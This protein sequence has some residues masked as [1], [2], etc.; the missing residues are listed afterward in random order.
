MLLFQDRWPCSRFAV[1][2]ATR[3]TGTR[4]HGTKCELSCLSEG[5][6]AG[7]FGS[8]RDSLKCIGCVGDFFR[9]GPSAKRKTNG[10]SGAFHWQSHE[11]PAPTGPLRGWFGDGAEPVVT[12]PKRSGGAAPTGSSAVLRGAV[13]RH[14]RGPRPRPAGQGL[15]RERRGAPAGRATA[16][17]RRRRAIRRHRRRPRALPH[18]PAEVKI[19]VLNGSGLVGVAGQAT[20]ILN[21]KGYTTIPPANAPAKVPATV[22]YYT[23]GYQADAEAIAAA[24]GTG[25]IGEF[26]R[27]RPPEPS[28]RCRPTCRGPTSSSCSA[29]T[30]RRARPDPTPASW[31]TLRV[32]RRAGCRRVGGR[33]RR[34]AR[35]A[36]RRASR[37]LR[38]H[39]RPDRAR[40]RRRPAHR[41][42]RG[43]AGGSCP[44]PRGRC[45]ARGRGCAPQ[46][47]VPATVV[48]SGVAK[49]SSAASGGSTP[50][51]GG[52]AARWRRRSP[53]RSPTHRPGP[54][55]RARGFPSRST[56][57]SVPTSREPCVSTRRP[58]RSAAVSWPG[59]RGCRWSCIRRSRPEGSALEE[60]S[61]GL[62]G[63]VRRRRCRRPAGLR[64]ARPVAARPGV[65]TGKVAV[66]SVEASP[67]LLVVRRRGRRPRGSA[68]PSGGA[69]RRGDRATDASATSRPRPVARRTSC[70]VCATSPRSA[71]DLRRVARSPGAQ[72]LGQDVG[73]P[74]TSWLTRSGISQL[75]PGARLG[76]E[77]EHRVARAIMA[78]FATRFMPSR[79]GF[80]EDDVGPLEPGHRA[81]K[82]SDRSSARSASRHRRHRSL[83]RRLSVSTSCR[84]VR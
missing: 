51:P 18:Q 56:T 59:R 74:A 11:G 42:R 2:S 55:S 27:C 35:H 61:A 83:T 9:G 38:R 78:S 3:P 31:W 24:L 46:R 6:F 49:W 45:R 33:R 69:G 14:R 75:V 50:T 62:S 81:G 17:P 12:A 43:G 13:R 48:L 21:G 34:S 28:L 37:G 20:D 71:G 54:A 44:S 16:R 67:E 82:S 77:R 36:A 19:L 68:P 76:A 23:E 53:G 4:L 8:L 32:G 40:S 57:G 29:P 47:H 1:R 39:A 79:I 80:D 15:P 22:V 70:R 60:L 26:S 30:S 65:R 63:G 84:Y 58:R 10:R 66:R 7:V 41:R 5:I 72:R 25:A 52:G 64:R 73:V